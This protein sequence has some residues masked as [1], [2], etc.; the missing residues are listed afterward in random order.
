MNLIHFVNA[1]IYQITC[2]PLNKIYIGESINV[3]DRLGRHT[4]ALTRQTHDCLQL[5]T[6]WNKYGKQHF[7][8]EILFIGEIWEHSIKRIQKQDE[9]ILQ[10][11]LSQRYNL[12]NKENIYRQL[13]QIDDQQFNSIVEAA[14]RLQ[15]SETTIRR[16]LNSNRYINYTRQKI[17][18]GKRVSIDGKISPSITKVVQLGIAK[19]RLQVYRRLNSQA[20]KW[21]QWYYI[22]EK[23]KV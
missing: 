19:N 20:E 16:R 5:Q 10:L 13:I 2:L 18:I 12:P 23:R 11:S 1:G 4:S 14:Q 21:Q 3:L 17:E 22:D 6:D 7:A 9:L 8:I 15:V